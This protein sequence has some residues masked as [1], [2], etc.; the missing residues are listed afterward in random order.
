MSIYIHKSHNV[1]VLIYHLVCP[2]KYR[3][4]V[5]TEKVDMVLKEACLGIANRY[6]IHFLEIGADKD[7]VHFLIQSVPTY[8]PTKI[9]RIVKSIT[10]REIFAQAPEVK[11][12]LWG[13]GFWSDGY[14]ISTIGKH[15]SEKAVTTYV[16]NQGKE[17]EY[18][19]FHQGQLVML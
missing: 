8:A 19:K 4:V 6:Q 13:G 3:R 5:I 10:A 18:V 1:S 9:S 2:T 12:A 14:Y 16:K 15:G 17:Q 7:H 11:Q